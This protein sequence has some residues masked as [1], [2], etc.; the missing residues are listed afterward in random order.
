[1]GKDV[2]SNDGV[3]IANHLVTEDPEPP[4]SYA[5]CSDTMYYPEIIPQIKNATVLYHESTFLEE[6]KELAEPTKHSTAIEAATIAKEA[7]VKNLVLGH[8]S[9]RYGSILPFKSEAE[10]V[11]PRVQLADDGKSFEF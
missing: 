4:I 2:D 7:E 11:F 3:T 6:N 10:T 5:Y 9:T 8:Y 1:M